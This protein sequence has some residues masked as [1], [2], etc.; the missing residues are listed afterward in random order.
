MAV[1]R[2]DY[3]SETEFRNAQVDEDLCNAL[4][5]Q[6]EHQKRMAGEAYS[7]HV[8]DAVIEGYKHDYDELLKKY[9]NRVDWAVVSMACG[10]YEKRRNECGQFNNNL[11]CSMLN[12]PYYKAH[13]DNEVP[14]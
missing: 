14:I 10:Y 5:E 4:W 13:Q 3:A 1:E 12:C 7:P 2:I 6:E 11:S 9:N 8:V